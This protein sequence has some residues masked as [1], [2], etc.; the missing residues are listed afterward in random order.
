MFSSRRKI[1]IYFL[2]WHWKTQ[3]N[4]WRKSLKNRSGS[5]AIP[6]KIMSSVNY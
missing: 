5:F 1:L 6:W 4:Q 3:M 2:N